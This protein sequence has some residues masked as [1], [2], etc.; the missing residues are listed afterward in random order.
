MKTPHNNFKLE[1]LNALKNLAFFIIIIFI[2][3]FSTNAQCVT[4]NDCDGDGIVNSIDL[5]DDNDGIL[6]CEENGLNVSSLSSLF[7]LAGSASIVNSNEIEL[8][9]DLQTQAGSS[10]SFG[11]I[12]F[13]NN[14]N[15]SIEINLGTKDIGADGIAIVFHNDPTGINTVGISG[16]GIGAWQIKNGISIEFD[17]Y[18]NNGEL[19]NDHTQI[20]NTRTW[21]EL[22]SMTDL[23]NIEDGKWHLVSFNWNAN[24]KTL[25]YSFDGNFIANYT[26]DLIA[27][28]F[29]GESKVHFGFTA[30]TGGQRNSQ[31]IRFANNLCTYPLV[32]D[33]DNDGIPNHFDTD[34][35]NDGCPDA[36]EGG[37]NFTITDING[38]LKG[39]V[40]SNGI[41][42][43]T[44][45]LNQTIG[46][47]LDA[48]ILSTVCTNPYNP[49]MPANCF[50]V[51]VE[52]NV[53]L[54]SG[55][56]IGSFAAGGDITINGDY[57]VALQ[58][59]GCFNI[60]GNDIGLLV[61]GKVNYNN[62][63]LNIRNASQFVKIGNQNGANAWYA[64][65]ENAPT[66]IRITPENIYYSNS[67]IQLSGNASN[68]NASSSTNSVFEKNVI[69]FPLA[70]QRL[71]TNATSMS[72]NVH[73]ASLKDANG[74]SITNTNLPNHIEVFL[75][76]GANY[77]NINAADLNNVQ[78]FNT[79]NHADSDKFL[80]INI[81]APGVFNWNVWSQG[82]IDNQDAA[83]IIYNFYNTTELNLEGSNTIYGSILAPFASITKS[84][85]K[86][87]VVGQVI[88]SSYSQDGGIIHCSNFKSDINASISVNVSPIAEFTV[89]NN[90]C[91]INN[92]FVFKNT[93]NTYPAAQPIEP[94]SYSWDFGDGT[95]SVLMEPTKTYALSGTY[96]VTLVATNVFG[97]NSKTLQ[98]TVLPKIDS[99]VTINTT[100]SGNNSVDKYVTLLNPTD[101]TSYEWTLPGEIT[102][103]HQ[104]QESVTMSFSQAG[105]Y[106]LTF[107]G[108]NT[109][110]CSVETEISITVASAEVT[111][112]NAGGVESESLGDA[113]SKIY[114]NR[115]KNSVPTEFVKSEENLYSK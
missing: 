65:P 85:N 73:N 109:N 39:G 40:D 62:G 71:R 45:G 13:N 27:N 15:F 30:S 24:S 9:P 80:I 101:F 93:S 103:S 18:Q 75:N 26:D 108:I 114:V 6:D 88:A 66:P 28:I 50:N 49:T 16:Q 44:L 84:V 92:T 112:G 53:T 33:S 4:I 74:N 34:S 31:K 21:A 111:T 102:A 29:N 58:D 77:I 94:I 43:I 72:E 61:G 57:D 76:N 113:I 115:K 10:M 2:N 23:G 105:I 3:I 83:H 17:T 69:D 78:V 47:S 51:F 82:G 79:Q 97:S 107:S 14:F 20:K 12:D 59:C 54:T 22:T 63:K 89:N 19:I 25:S 36:L 60:N 48:S 81:N 67:Y 46:T 64:D 106:T 32:I 8:T 99:Q 42:L 55:N 5:D 100:N 96:T 104:N 56:T 70:F 38:R 86:A 95:N 41:P 87:D 52:K 35:D 37:G 90:E 110:G 68:F 98:V 91:L 1:N 7:S 11:K